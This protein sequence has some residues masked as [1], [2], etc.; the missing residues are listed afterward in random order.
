MRA[1]ISENRQTQGSILNRAKQLLALQFNQRD[2][3]QKTSRKES[4]QISSVIAGF[5]ELDRIQREEVAAFISIQ[6]IN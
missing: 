3:K 2:L 1:Q 6:L 4:I 5:L